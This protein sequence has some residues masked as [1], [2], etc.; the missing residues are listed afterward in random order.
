MRPA[1]AL[2][3]L[4]AVAAAPSAARAAQ[5][6]IV[7]SELRSEGL[8][9]AARAFFL[10]GVSEGV[11]ATGAGL[12]APNTLQAAVQERPDL[13]RCED[14]PCWLALARA[15]RADAVV[16]GKV[17]KETVRGDRERARYAV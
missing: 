3:A 15:T 9:E 17:T 10:S 16:A 6:Q 4:A 5:R 2:A 12:V 11:E 1:L 13:E 8:D 7:V 14:D